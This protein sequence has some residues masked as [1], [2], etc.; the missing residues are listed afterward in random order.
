MPRS[1]KIVEVP[2]GEAV[3]IVEALMMDG[4]LDTKV[5]EEYRARYRSEV[6]SLE[7]RIAR[8][9]SLA[10]PLAPAAIGAVAAAA[11]P[12]VR[13]RVKKAVQAAKA[14][15]S[16]GAKPVSPERVKSRALQG[17]YLGLMRQ[18]PKSVV[19]KQFGRDAIAKQ[20]KEKVISEMEKYLSKK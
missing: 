10:A 2:A 7:S 3:F 19:K 1:R 11:V 17:K 18:I 9:R 8:L 5:L 6:A 16:G 14:A 20:G 15:V 13:R 4:R 12:A